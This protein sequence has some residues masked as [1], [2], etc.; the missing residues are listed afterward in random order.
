MILRQKIQ[1]LVLFLLIL[2][3]F[4]S[5][6]Q[7]TVAWLQWTTA[8]AIFFFM[9]VFDLTFTNDSNFIF[10]PDA[11]NWR[12]KTVRS[13]KRAYCSACL[14]NL[15]LGVEWSHIHT[16]PHSLTYSSFSL[17]HYR[18][19]HRAL[20]LDPQYHLREDLLLVWS[21]YYTSLPTRWLL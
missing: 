1:V 13:Q 5:Y 11:E 17:S 4:A 3:A 12:R 2:L 10:D 15:D 20:V 14:P 19:L 9:F 7:G 16:H 21:V 8:I 18:K 6:S